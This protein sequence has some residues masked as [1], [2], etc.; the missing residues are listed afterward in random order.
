MKG[1]DFRARRISLGY[2]TVADFARDN[3]LYPSTV[4]KLENNVTQF[5]H[6]DYQTQ[7]H[8]AAALRCQVQDLLPLPDRREQKC[9]VRHMKPA[10]IE[11]EL[12]KKYG[13]KLEPID[14]ERRARQKPAL[15][16]IEKWGART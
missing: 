10:E 14:L 16:Q 7:A 15:Y 13:V 2:E 12:Q 11:V 4:Y 6:M 3:H 1:S 5:W 8:V 9:S